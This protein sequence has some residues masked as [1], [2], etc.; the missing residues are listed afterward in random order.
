VPFIP[1]RLMVWP[2][3][4]VSYMVVG[5]VMLTSIYAILKF[6][7]GRMEAVVPVQVG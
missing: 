4:Y 1:E 2:L 7:Q 6:F 3:N 5:L